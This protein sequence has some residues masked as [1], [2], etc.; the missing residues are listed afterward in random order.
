MAQEFVDTEF[1][2]SCCTEKEYC[3]VKVSNSVLLAED[4]CM[5]R[6]YTE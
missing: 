1:I 4:L 6:I 5:V 3:G 2:L